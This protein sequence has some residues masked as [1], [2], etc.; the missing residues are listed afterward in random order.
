VFHSKHTF[1]KQL[2]LFIVLGIILF[3]CKK[4]SSTQ[5]SSTPS[6]NYIVPN[7]FKV[8]EF[9]VHAITGSDVYT[10]LFTYDSIGNV[11]RINEVDSAF[12][13]VDSFNFTYS[14][15]QLLSYT[16][17]NNYGNNNY[18]GISYC[19][20]NGQII[21]DSSSYLTYGR[22]EQLI[23][24]NGDTTIINRR[25]SYSDTLISK[26]GNIINDNDGIQSSTHT[27]TSYYNPFQE[28]NLSPILID[29][30]SSLG[31]NYVYSNSPS[32]SYSYNF[33]STSTGYGYSTTGLQ[34]QII[35]DSLNRITKISYQSRGGNLITY[36]DLFY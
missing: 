11:I 27:Y 35:T 12:H 22:E 9:I 6:T 29:F 26:N 15:N 34:Q 8:K 32:N 33:V 18:T 16:F 24:Y 14:Y 19:N 36:I 7:Q 2:T 21:Y 4:D 1:M 23:S 17:K 3:S 28:L 10:T 30:S 31:I 13:N 5:S 20:S 25:N